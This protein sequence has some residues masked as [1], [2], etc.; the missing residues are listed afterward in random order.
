MTASVNHKCW[1]SRLHTRNDKEKKTGNGRER[2]RRRRG[3]REMTEQR[4][5]DQSLKIKCQRGETLFTPRQMNLRQTWDR[6]FTLKCTARI[7]V[8]RQN[9]YTADINYVQ[10]KQTSTNAGMAIIRPVTCFHRYVQPHPR[11]TLHTLVLVW[12]FFLRQNMVIWSWSYSHLLLKMEPSAVK[13]QCQTLAVNPNEQI[14]SVSSEVSLLELSRS[15][16]QWLAVSLS[17]HLCLSPAHM[18]F[19]ISPEKE[20]KCEGR[21]RSVSEPVNTHWLLYSDI[22]N[23]AFSIKRTRR[24]NNSQAKPGRKVIWKWFK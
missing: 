15:L 24:L 11:H 23:A 19:L 20:Y 1:I 6:Q 5:S 9:N 22:S 8:Q 16:L 2:E 10:Y 14:N 12:S 18:G 17:V 21:C 7:H 13:F 4:L 3:G